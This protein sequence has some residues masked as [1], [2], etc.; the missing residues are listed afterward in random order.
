MTLNDFL[1]YIWAPV[2]YWLWTEIRDL[3]R[4]AQ[5]NITRE[6]ASKMIS[7]YLEPRLEPMQRTIDKTAATV[8]KFDTR[9]N[10]IVLL[11]AT[12]RNQ[13]KQ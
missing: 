9:L 6:E 8:E 7:E 1:Q 5:S 12:W 10:E 2:V 4:S 11:L 3:R 13:D